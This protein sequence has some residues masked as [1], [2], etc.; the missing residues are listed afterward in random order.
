M[1]LSAWCH[2]HHILQY[3]YRRRGAHLSFAEALKAVTDGKH[4]VPLRDA[5]P[6]GRPDGG[7]HACRRGA[8]IQDRH[9]EVALREHRGK[10]GA[11]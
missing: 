11:N 2:M 6:D 10:N 1:H 5:H 3:K 4:L 9:V 8:H 7:V